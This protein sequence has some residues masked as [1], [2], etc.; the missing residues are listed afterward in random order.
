MTQAAPRTLIDNA[1]LLS[2]LSLTISLLSACSDVHSDVPVENRDNLVI[3]S[4]PPHAELIRRI[5]GDRVRV[6]TLVRPGDDPH[7]FRPADRVATTVFRS[8]VFFH[9]GGV[10][11]HGNWFQAV[12]DTPRG[13]RLV[14]LGSIALDHVD[15]A[16]HDEHGHLG[17]AAHLWLNFGM[18][19]MQV[20]TIVPV[21]SSEWPEHADEFQR[22]ARALIAE[23]QRTSGG[24][25]A[26][27][28]SESYAGPR[29]IFVGH[30]SLGAFCEFYGLEQVALEQEERP[31]SDQRT[32]ELLRRARGL[33]IKFVVV[34]AS[35][36]G[37]AARHFAA[38]IGAET[39][40]FDPLAPD[41]LA[42]LE[43]LARALVATAPGSSGE[44]ESGTGAEARP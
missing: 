44:K 32:T 35:A 14:N 22:N 11:E 8:R 25:R 18:L 10:L 9:A 7:T 21:L 16:D 43:R 6:V 13:P 12:R 26:M 31:P 40:A 41:V 33:K 5:A 4:I 17:E 37:R 2:V 36:S 27:L 3:A 1:F 34:D 19:S 30:P 39:F 24:I 15:P 20:R 28:A 38:A 23:I 42:N 29:T